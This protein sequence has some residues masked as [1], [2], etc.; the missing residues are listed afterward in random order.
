MN[1][2]PPPCLA[3]QLVER[4]QALIKEHGD[5]PVFARD[6]DTRYRLP[7][8]LEFRERDADG[9][10]PAR[11]EVT[12]AYHDE[13]RSYLSPLKD[14]VYVCPT[15]DIVCGSNP[16]TWCATCPQRITS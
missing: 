9:E 1:E 6:P 4:L 8:G 13:P 15:R 16:A 10:R 11:F 5:L 3:S 12:T 2:R 7:V 14:M